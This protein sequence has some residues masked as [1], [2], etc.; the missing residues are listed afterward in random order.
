[1]EAAVNAGVSPRIVTAPADGWLGEQFLFDFAPNL[2]QPLQFKESWD[3]TFEKLSDVLQI[4][5]NMNR[6]APQLYY[7]HWQ[8]LE[9]D[10]ADWRELDNGQL[11]A[12][13]TS[14]NQT[15]FKTRLSL[16]YTHQQYRQA[17]DYKA[18]TFGIVSN[19]NALLEPA[20]VPNDYLSA[21]NI[22]TYARIAR[23]LYAGKIDDAIEQVETLLGTTTAGYKFPDKKALFTVLLQ[24]LAIDN[25]EQIF[26]PRFKHVGL[27]F[28]DALQLTQATYNMECV[29]YSKLKY[30]ENTIE[31]PTCEYLP[32]TSGG[33][34]DECNTEF[35]AFL[36]TGSFQN[37]FHEGREDA[38]DIQGEYLCTNGEKRTYFTTIST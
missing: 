21:E 24:I 27:W 33:N 26:A 1:M 6:Y 15:A 30:F 5:A 10:G 32:S 2:G 16:E 7:G 29:G 19:C 3:L 12:T 23:Q 25:S 4:S 22:V 14:K 11:R 20:E 37:Q 31:A 35:Q 17:D 38:S 18:A 8:R 36:Q 9:A 13:L 34:S 28:T